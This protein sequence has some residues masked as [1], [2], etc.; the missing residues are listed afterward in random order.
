MITDSLIT[1]I[2]DE[3]AKHISDEDIKRALIERGWEETDVVR[4]LAGEASNTILPSFGE[5]LSQTISLAHS[6]LKLLVTLALPWA[7]LSLLV[8]VFLSQ[9]T[10]GKGTPGIVLLGT[11]AVV[12][13]QALLSVLATISTIVSLSDSTISDP[14]VAWKKGFSAMLR[15]LATSFVS[16]VWVLIGFILLIIPGFYFMV[17]VAF[18]GIVSVLEGTGATKSMDRS[19]SY[20]KGRWWAVAWRF[21]AGVVVVIL[22][23]AVVNGASE[24]GAVLVP[25]AKVQL[26][27]IATAFSVVTTVF[28]TVYLYVLY[29]HVSGKKRV[30]GGE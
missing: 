18:S 7:I 20:V 2:T 22:A 6:R 25:S 5:L 15:Y 9:V 21:F 28:S 12:L 16:S 13:V 24:F 14:M 19:E 17:K 26:A 1:Y 8:S 30:G 3:R 27:M 23:S 29:T 11:V 10:F 4:A